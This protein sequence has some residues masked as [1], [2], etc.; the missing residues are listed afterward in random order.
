MHANPT[1]LA[2]P[3]D[4]R[5]S[6]LPDFKKSFCF[7]RRKK[8]SI[9]ARRLSV[10]LFSELNQIEFDDVQLCFCNVLNTIITTICNDIKASI[11]PPFALLLS[12]FLFLSQSLSQSCHWVHVSLQY[13]TNLSTEEE[14]R[15]ENSF[16]KFVFINFQ[17]IY[18]T[19]LQY[20]Q[21]DTPDAR[22]PPIKTKNNK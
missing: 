12:G 21:Q 8:H 4:I 15:G 5:S 10:S 11:F 1:V 3:T 9:S 7:F 18:M 17:L 6:C 16:F 19:T 13:F 22:F 20:A 2:C 14:K